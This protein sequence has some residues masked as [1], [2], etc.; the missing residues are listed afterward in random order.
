VNGLRP[1]GI[2]AA[3]L[4]PGW[5]R[6]ELVLHASRPVEGDWRQV[7]ALRRAESTPYVRRAVVAPA[8]KRAGDA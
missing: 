4:S 1:H 7:E 8:R 2:A 5:M 6:A 3:A